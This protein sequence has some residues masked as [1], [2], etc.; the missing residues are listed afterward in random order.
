LFIFLDTETTGTENKDR[1]CQLA[2]KQNTGEIVNELFKPP[3]PIEIEAMSI[4]HIT[5]EMVADRPAFK[6]SHDYQKLFD[7][8]NDDENILV[9]HNANFDVDMLIKEG[10]HPKKFICTLK[11]ARHLDPN[12]VIPKYN[13]QYLRYF[14]G[15]KIQATAHDAL[16]D[17]LVLEK[18]FERLF[19]RMNKDFSSD[20]VEDKMIEVSNNPVLLSRMLFGKHKGQL[21]KDIPVDYLQWL[22][23]KNDLDE[24]MRYTIDHYLNP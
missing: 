3:L 9:A 24:D 17:I 14:L 11:L 7:L 2:Y 6:D 15:I 10:I 13:L 18:L 22:S 1:L 16:G 23:G 21:F 20:Q 4:H 8:L 5:N 19:A 12:G